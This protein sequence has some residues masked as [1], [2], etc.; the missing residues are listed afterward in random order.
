[1]N[2]VKKT[3][4]LAESVWASKTVHLLPEPPGERA[5]LVPAPDG[6]TENPIRLV[7]VG[8]SLIA[9]SGVDDQSEALTPLIA[10]RVAALAER[11]VYWQTHAKLGATMRRVRHRFLPEVE[12]GADILVVCAGSNDILARRSRAEWI[13]DLNGALDEAERLGRRVVVMSSGQ[14]HHSPKLP[15]LLKKEIAKRIDAQTEDSARICAERSMAFIDVAHFERIDGFWASDGF[16]PSKRGYEQ[17]A[18][19]VVAA[20]RENWYG[21]SASHRS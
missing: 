14:P 12:A 20:T 21:V 5:G 19:L 18:D 1:M 10:E 7:A 6:S 11:P 15:T 3:I 16:H 8:D 4:L 2:P 17:A 9:G 13:D